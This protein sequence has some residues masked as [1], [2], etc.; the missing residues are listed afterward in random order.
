MQK[1]N[2]GRNKRD[3]GNYGRGRRNYPA[4][5]VGRKNK[6]GIPMQTDRPSRI[7]RE[8]DDEY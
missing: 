2:D 5:L 3:N 8:R 6:H 4:R 7:N 1:G